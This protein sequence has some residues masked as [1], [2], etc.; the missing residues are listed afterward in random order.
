[1]DG[2]RHAGLV[3]LGILAAEGAF[4]GLAARSQEPA[5]A[6]QATTQAVA[7]SSTA[8]QAAAPPA[9]P[10]NCR[11]PA[12]RVVVDVG[13]TTGDPGALSARGVTEYDF[14]LKLAGKVKQALV[15]AGFDKTVLMITTKPPYGG[16]FER[17]ARANA[18]AA[19]LFIAVHHDSVPDRLLQNWSFEGKPNRYNDNWPGYALFISNDN[20]QH[21]ASL[22]FGKFLGKALQAHGLKFTSHYILPIM[23]SRRRIL[24]DADA[25]VYRYDQ[26]VVLRSTHMP[27]LLIEAGSIVNRDEEIELATDERRAATSAAVAEAVGEFCTARAHPVAERAEQHAAP[28]KPA[29]AKTKTATS[30]ATAQPAQGIKWPWSR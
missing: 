29:A 25:G 2:L 22:E 12:F 24:L 15:D 16:L 30:K 23:G 3:L 20:P 9:T 8:A 6:D 18:L 7:P 17:A 11:R 26:L 5:P 1:M 14:N 10:D 19:D 4:G 21:A 13:H 28:A 27:A